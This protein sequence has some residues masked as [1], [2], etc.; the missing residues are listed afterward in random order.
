MTKSFY[1]TPITGTCK[2][3]SRK[4]WLTGENRRYRAY[5][6][7]LMRKERYDDIQSFKGRFGNEWT[8]PRDGKQYFGHM[9]YQNCYDNEICYLYGYTTIKH[10]TSNYHYY[11]CKE[12]YKRYMRK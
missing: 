3:I 12:T 2:C 7:N 1:K 8:S 11:D 10:C 5:T 9:K 4:S 6:T